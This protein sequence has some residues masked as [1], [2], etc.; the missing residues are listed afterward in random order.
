MPPRV[1][2]RQVF[3][4][5]SLARRAMQ[6]SRSKPDSLHRAPAGFTNLVLDGY[7]LR[8]LLPARPTTA[9]PRIRF[10]FV[11]SRL[12]STLPSDSSSRFCPCASLVLHLHQVAQGT[13]T[14]KLSD[15]SDT[16]GARYARIAAG[17]LRPCPRPFPQPL[18]SAMSSMHRCALRS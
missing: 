1:N 16:Q 14:P 12:C 9:L 15:M 2:S 3:V 4:S 13:F 5:S 6:I 11:G 10:L 17:D 18:C 8:G 7:G